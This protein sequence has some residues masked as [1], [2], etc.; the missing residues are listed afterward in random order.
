MKNK[1]CA[2]A[3]AVF[4][5]V[6]LA[7]YATKTGY[8][9]QPASQNDQNEISKEDVKKWVVD[10][11]ISWSKPGISM[12]PPAMESFEDGKERYEQIAEAALTT[13]AKNKPIFDGQN[14]RI[15][16]VALILS[17]S[18]FESAYKKD[19]DMNLGNLG[20]GDGGRSWCLMQIQ[21]GAPILIDGSGKRVSMVKECSE[22]ENPSGKKSTQC[23]YAPPQ[24]SIQS[25]PTRIVLF[26]DDYELTHDQTRG[27]SGQDL[28]E[29]R[30]LCFTA[31]MRIIRK[32]L[33]ACKHLP[34][35][36]RLSVYT[37][38]SCDSGRESSRRRMGAAVQ[39]FSSSPPPVNDGQLIKLFQSS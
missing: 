21:L 14:G 36:E 2:F 10:R 7:F 18:M 23:K 9:N 5:F 26:D 31:G 8:A 29:D 17:V 4:M 30:E 20:R 37:S 19:V 39:W 6:F 33:F 11:M 3:L 1:I 22:I 13:V 28:V 27:H 32:S 34:L 16:T 24:G 15:K 25:T 35:L 12:H 38:G